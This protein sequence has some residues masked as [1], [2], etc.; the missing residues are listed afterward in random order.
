[1]DVHRPGL[2]ET[3]STGDVLRG[4]QSGAWQETVARVRSL[5]HDSAEQ[6]TAKCA[7]PFATWAGVFS[8]RANSALVQHSGQCGVD[9]D[10]LGD[11][12]A[13]AVIQTAVADKHCLAAF[14]SARGE[15]VRL[16]FR[17]PPCSAR[18]H[19]GVF[20][21]VSEHVRR[22]YSRDPDTSGSDVSR[23]S[24]VSFDNGLWFF[25][26]AEVLPIQLPG[27]IHSGLKTNTAVYHSVYGGQ[28]ALTCWT[29]YGRHSANTSPR[30]DGTAKT[31]RSL[32][33]LGKAVALHAERIGERLTERHISLA[34]EAWVIRQIKDP[35]I[36]EFWEHEF[37]GYDERF[38]REA[39]APIQNK[40]GQFLLNPV[41]RNILGQVK[42]KVSFPFVM[43]RPPGIL[44]KSGSALVLRKQPSNAMSNLCSAGLLV[45]TSQC[46]IRFLASG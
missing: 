24:F 44:G 25:G 11:D 39:I 14:R 22:I 27:M 36:K 20:E 30:A 4:I 13:T 31:H 37:A 2:L 32:L 10:D 40:L 8:Y 6:K 43:D 1:M 18:E 45:C 38:R 9:L 7:L 15:G 42:C 28:L 17:V 3:R 29:W 21:Q 46:W 35:F 19:P 26:L 34:F 16:L 41:I 33:D 12:G 5:P 23:A